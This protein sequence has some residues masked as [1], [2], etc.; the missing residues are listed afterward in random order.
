MSVSPSLDHGGRPRETVVA[1]VVWAVNV[2]LR[3]ATPWHGGLLCPARVPELP[4]RH[5]PL[6]PLAS[7]DEGCFDDAAALLGPVL[8]KVERRSGEIV[9]DAALRAYAREVAASELAELGERRR[10]AVG[11]PHKLTRLATA[12]WVVRA[13]PD[14]ADRELL[15]HMLAWLG[16]TS[17]AVGAVGWPLESWAARHGRSVEAMADWVARVVTTLREREPRRYERFV[18]VPLAG[19][20]Q[21]VV[22]LA[23][24]A[25]DDGG[26][27]EWCEETRTPM[28]PPWRDGGSDEESP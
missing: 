12:R 16:G 11:I 4:G 18:R 13:L 22:P 25:H 6:E 28:R 15:L 20:P 3:R 26:L 17:P 8:A 1:I 24:L 10:A 9:H 14:V 5:G 21:V 19:K 7:C 23:A 2:G 27:P